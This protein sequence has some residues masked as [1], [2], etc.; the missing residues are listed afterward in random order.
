MVL[1]RDLNAAI[2]L[3]N[4][5]VSSID[6]QNA[7]GVGSSGILETGCETSYV[8]AATNQH[9]G[10]SYLSKVS[11]ANKLANW[12]GTSVLFTHVTSVHLVKL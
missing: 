5:V 3:R 9:V 10:M 6:T 4:V 1:D 12:I 8:E 7:C 2:N 11:S